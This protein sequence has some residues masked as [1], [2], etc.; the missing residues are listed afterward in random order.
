MSGSLRALCDSFRI[1]SANF[2]LRS[3]PLRNNPNFQAVFFHVLRYFFESKNTRHS[4][5]SG[6]EL[7]GQYKIEATDVLVAMTFLPLLV[8]SML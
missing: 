6:Q 7:L 8:E 4:S 5:T 1:D 2:F 3:L